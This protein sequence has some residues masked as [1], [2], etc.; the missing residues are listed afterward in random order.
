MK[1]RT[2]ACLAGLVWLAGCGGGSGSPTNPTPGPTPA[3]TPTPGPPPAATPTPPPAPGP[4][5]LRSAAMNGANGHSGGGT[6]KIVQ[7]G[8][9]YRLEFSS[10]FRVSGAGSS[11]VYLTN[12]TRGVGNGLNLG[13]LR[14]GSGAQSYPMPNDG[15]GYRYVLIWCR[16]FTIPI[17]LGDL[18]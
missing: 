15:G 6:A 7:D 4:V 3:A 9:Q 12:S 17:G 11:D 14:S 13:N 18:Q 2:L 16:P 10:S 5:T 1:A 8:G